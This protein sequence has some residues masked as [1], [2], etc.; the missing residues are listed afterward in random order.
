MWRAPVLLLLGQ[1]FISTFASPR[2]RQQPHA[3][4]FLGRRLLYNHW[5]FE[6]VTPGNLEREC[7]EE[8]CNYEEAREVFE[9][10]VAT[11][12]YRGGGAHTELGG[13]TGAWEAAEGE[14]TWVPQ[15]D[16]V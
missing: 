10:D 8:V 14:G 6:L 13:V 3:Q 9:D 16:R 2:N 15:G 7:L 11:A 4:G 1:A 12:E 5:D